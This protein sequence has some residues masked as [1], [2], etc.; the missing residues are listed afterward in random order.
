M[1]P[2]T[3]LSAALL[4]LSVS[5]LP[6]PRRPRPEVSSFVTGIQPIPSRSVSSVPPVR[7]STA[8]S[9][10]PAGSTYTP[11]ARMNPKCY[12][13]NM[14]TKSPAPNS[15]PIYEI[16]PS[17][18]QL[19]ERL[20]DVS[21]RDASECC[22]SCV[23]D[24]NCAAMAYRPPQMSHQAWGQCYHALNN[25]NATNPPDTRCRAG[26][27][28]TARQ[29]FPENQAWTIQSGLCGKTNFMGYWTY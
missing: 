8:T 21:A 24:P 2:S 23:D 3:I 26:I 20:I 12:Y 10:A 4:A 9:V 6:E 28:Y 16:Q 7:S 11:P 1:H 29:T 15:W 17:N 22:Q 14:I 18:G 25:L 19:R 13:S 5:A 27:D